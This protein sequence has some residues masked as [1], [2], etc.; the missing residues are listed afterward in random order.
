VLL[1]I[2]IA[3]ISGEEFILYGKVITILTAITYVS[4]FGVPVELVKQYGESKITI[5]KYNETLLPLHIISVII[6]YIITFYF[7]NDF[8]SLNFFSVL[9]FLFTEIISNDI[10]RL[11]QIRSA[12][13]EHIIFSSIKSLSVF[14]VLFFFY[15]ES[16]KISFNI[17][18]LLNGI[19][20]LALLL[21]ASYFKSI[22]NFKLSNNFSFKLIKYSLPFFFM[23]LIEKYALSY[24]RLYLSMFLDEMTFKL[25]LF[26]YPLFMASFNILE[27]TVLL[28][29]Y[30]DVF[31]GKFEFSL[32]L[33]RISIISL[34]SFPIS[35]IVYFYLSFF[36]KINTSFIYLLLSSSLYIFLSAIGWYLNILNFKKTLPF[37]FL[38]ITV[39]IVILYFGFVSI[40]FYLKIKL[41]YILMLLLPISVIFSNLIFLKGIGFLKFRKYLNNI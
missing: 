21:Y 39:F 35:L 30:S 4:G 24:D 29:W 3:F 2:P 40:F 11:Y 32:F 17:F 36:H 26:V 19:I 31:S 14:L 16:Y 6:F 38:L 34:I 25:F 20:N 41:V 33:K 18:L 22:A 28:K 37:Q 9:L 27:G 5:K 8:A 1:Y 12:F 10:L 15:Y 13:K 7:S 23:Y